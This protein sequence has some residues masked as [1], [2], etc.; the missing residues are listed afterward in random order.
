MST[1][2]GFTQCPI[3]E[4]QFLNSFF[5]KHYSVCS[6]EKAAEDLVSASSPSSSFFSANQPNLD[7]TKN[8]GYVVREMG[9]YGSHPSHDGF[10]DESES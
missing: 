2:D 1:R 7:A 10:N 8:I 6:E 9:K 5:E 3:C 4:A